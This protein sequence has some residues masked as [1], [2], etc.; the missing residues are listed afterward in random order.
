MKEAKV[1]AVRR[2]LQEAR[3]PDHVEM[4]RRRGPL[5]TIR[6]KYLIQQARMLAARYSLE[7]TLDAFV[8]GAGCVAITGLDLD[9]LEQLVDRLTSAGVAIDAACDPIG[10]PP[11]R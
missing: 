4:A 7:V 8:Y 3:V 6:R 11:A 9:Q 2:L 10:V 1:S 5:G